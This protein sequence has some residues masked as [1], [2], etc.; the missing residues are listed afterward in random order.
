MKS[1]ILI[2]Y[3]NGKVKSSSLKKINKINLSDKLIKYIMIPYLQSPN[4]YIPI[5]PSKL[6]RFINTKIILEYQLMTFDYDS[7]DVEL[8]SSDIFTKECHNIIDFINVLYNLYEFRAMSILIND[9]R[10]NKMCTSMDLFH[11]VIYPRR[12]RI[13]FYDNSKTIAHVIDSEDMGGFDQF[14][15]KD[16]KGV[17]P[18][19]LAEDRLN[20]LSEIMF[21]PCGTNVNLSNSLKNLPIGIKLENDIWE[22]I[23]KPST[24]LKNED[25]F[26]YKLD[27]FGA[28]YILRY[29]MYIKL[30]TINHFTVQLIGTEIISNTFNDIN[31]FP[32]LDKNKC[33]HILERKEA[34]QKYLN[35][36]IFDIYNVS[37]YVSSVNMFL[38]TLSYLIQL[39][40]CLQYIVDIKLQESNQ[41]KK[42]ISI[43]REED[44]GMTRAIVLLPQE[45]NYDNLLHVFLSII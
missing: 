42:F 4:I 32:S 23:N 30:L 19:Y 10:E 22:K 35:D 40:N 33:P 34:I 2:L 14:S 31:I 20:C 16:F 12:I 9:Y 41:I 8:Y 7:M 39:F 3:K 6:Y 43:Y 17:P 13:E 21:T 25:Y 26:L 44:P 36:D 45:L 15:E 27:D 18:Q 24:E 37:L 5:K 11:W 29:E 28:Y 1:T 38:I